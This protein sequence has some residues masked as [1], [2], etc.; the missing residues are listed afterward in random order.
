[1]VK[2]LKT[3]K[4]G[5]TRLTTTPHGKQVEQFHRNEC[6][7]TAIDDLLRDDTPKA[8]PFGPRPSC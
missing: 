7:K 5:E 1:M 8:L 6:G 4:H 3:A 2:H